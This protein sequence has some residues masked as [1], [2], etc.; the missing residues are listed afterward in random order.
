[1]SYYFFLSLDRGNSTHNEI[2][3]IWSLLC[4]T[5]KLL[6]YLIFCNIWKN[7]RNRGNSAGKDAGKKHKLLIFNN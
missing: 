3:N 2:E 6:Y 7:H 4:K 5:H 1:M